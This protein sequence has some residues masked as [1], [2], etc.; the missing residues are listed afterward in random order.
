MQN[1]LNKSF[2]HRKYKIYIYVY[3]IN[4]LNN[5]LYL[6]VLEVDYSKDNNTIGI[7]TLFYNPTS[8]SLY[9]DYISITNKEFFDLYFSTFN[10]I[11]LIVNKIL[12][13]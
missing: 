6:N 4:E 11:K 10:N 5:N 3:D 1:S 8:N 9:Q 13:K 7:N 12:N 2:K